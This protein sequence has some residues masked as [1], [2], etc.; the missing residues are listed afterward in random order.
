MRYFVTGA[1]GFVGG[2]LVRKL[3]ER[4]HEVAALVRNLPKAAPLKE[5]GVELF[6]GDIT[7]RETIAPAMEG[8]DGVF[9]VAA[10]YKVGEKSDR[11][12]RINVEGTRNVLTVM[13]E[14]R[15]PKGVYTSSL[16]VYGDTH[17]R[18]V[19]E[20]YRTGDNP[21]SEY[22]RTKRIAHF[23]VAEPMMQEG[24]PLVIVLPGLVYGKGDTSSTADFVRRYLRKKLPLM[25]AGTSYCWG[26]VEDIV[27]GHIDAMDRGMPGESYNLAGP[28]HSMV[29][30]LRFSE[31]ITG[32]RPPRLTISGRLA[33]VF[34]AVMGPIERIIP[35]PSLFS[36][37]TL[38]VT[39]GVTYLG[40][41]G[42]AKKDLGFD[43]RSLEE[44]FPEELH[45]EMER[46][47]LA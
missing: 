21:L 4:G 43:V 18:L 23:D 2:Y 13:K 47:N 20:S 3:R 8:A 35:V 38:R 11:A 33:K 7:Q 41:N 36:S 25:I 19:D 26:H 6:Q 27:Q 32:V 16:V 22:E 17:G 1:T 5:I 10:W 24:L 14:L 39:A 44:G 28:V 40:S 12:Y 42:K 34:S 30:V 9:H 29:E 46:V 37:E 15:I 45:A 31:K